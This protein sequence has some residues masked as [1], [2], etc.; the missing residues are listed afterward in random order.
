MAGVLSLVGLMV[1][2]L[3]AGGFEAPPLSD[4]VTTTITATICTQCYKFHEEIPH[5]FPCVLVAA[6]LP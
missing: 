6:F 1:G 4:G 3:T 2:S 5:T